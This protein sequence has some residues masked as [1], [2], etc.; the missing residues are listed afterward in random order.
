M[1]KVYYPGRILERNVGGNTTYTRAIAEGI[2][3]YGWEVD[4]L[5]YHSKAPV[6]ALM[7]QYSALQK[8]TSGELVHYS[9]DTGPLIPVRRPSVVT[10]HGVASAVADA[11]LPRGPGCHICSTTRATLT[12]MPQGYRMG[13]AHGQGGRSGRAP[14]TSWAPPARGDAGPDG[15]AHEPGGPPSSMVPS[16]RPPAR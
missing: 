7:E 14:A 3:E 4:T 15:A 8:P 10:V 2:K 6:T 12:L 11:M 5:P 9:A 16:D 13:R 1:K